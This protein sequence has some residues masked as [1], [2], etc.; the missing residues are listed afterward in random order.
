MSI[1]NIAIIGGGV[2]GAGWAT[3]FLLNGYD[4][5]LYDPIKNTEEN[6]NRMCFNARHAYKS[7]SMDKPEGR[8]YIVDTLDK[9]VQNAH[10]I[11]EN[12]PENLEIKA[13]VY[14]QIEE[15]A[16]KNAIIGSSTSGFMPSELQHQLKNPERVIVAHPFNPVYLLPLVEVVTSPVNN[17]ELTEQAI[18]LFK[19]IQ[20]YPLLLRKE[21]PAHI[22][23]RLL[24]A[25]WR[26]SLWLIK[27]G[28]TTTEELDNAIT[29][30]FGLRWA[31][32]G[33]FETYRIA[34]GTAGMRHFLAQ[35]G[36][37]LGFEWTK[38]MNVPNLDEPL[39]ET[40]VEQS[41]MQSG[42][43]SIEQLERIRD[44]NI[45]GFLKV[46][47]KNNWGAGKF[48][49]TEPPTQEKPHF[50]TDEYPLQLYKSFVKPSYI[51]YNQHM[52]ESSYLE[53]FGYT[54]DAF[55]ERIGVDADYLSNGFSV[56]TVETHL[57]H[58][59][60]CKLG[61]SL[62]VTT[63]LLGIDNKRIWLCHEM[64]S[65]NDQL[66]TAEQM[67]LHVDTQQ[68]KACVFKKH[69]YNCLETIYQ[70]ANNLPKPDYVGKA[71]QAI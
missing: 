41:D 18:S 68:S 45:I 56:Y 14:K 48:L 12:V 70:Q 38:L 33:L 6:I 5:H 20:M 54:T 65:H 35:F 22:A 49:N 13:K 58:L 71:I 15:S 27:D 29:Y 26:E 57:R 17:K 50:N 42:E 16:P 30:G 39:I 52:T 37:A 53:V 60:D 34:G 46:L 4:I 32:M 55:L 28:I 1:H 21:I 47:K 24:E 62:H 59:K 19:S 51:D 64:Y 25:V 61:D 67:L 3:R 10:Y 43:Y 63:Q 23:D 2:I 40:I 9:A 69:I 8:L 66:A 11:Q 44:E 36:P 7:L 31:Q